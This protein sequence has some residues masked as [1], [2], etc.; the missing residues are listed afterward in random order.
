MRLTAAVKRRPPQVVAQGVPLPPPTGGWDAISPLANMPAD[1]AIKLDNWV[2]RPGWI[3]PRNGFLPRCTGLGDSRTSVQTVMAYNSFG[4]GVKLFGVAGNTIYDCSTV[5]TAVATNINALS[6]SRMQYVQFSNPSSVQYLFACNGIDEPVLYNGSTWANAIITGSGV[7]STTFI[8]VA[9]H[10]GRLWF[11]QANSTQAVYMALGAITGTGTVFDLGQFMSKGGYLVAIGTWTVDT[12]QTVDEYIAFMTS[13]GQVIVY[14]G[15]DPSTASTWNLVGRYDVGHPIGTRCFSRIA[16]DL[17]VITIDG[18]VGMSEMLST[19][20][21]AAN[22]VSLTSKIMN[23]MAIAAQQWGNNFGWQIMEYPKG[24]LSILN[25]PVQENTMQQQ[26][27]M[28]TITGAWCRFT[29]INAN[30]WEVDASDNIFFGGND[31]TVYQW[32]VGSSDNGT[33][34]TCTVETAYNAFG[35]AAQ[36]KRYTMLQ[37]L[38]TTTGTPIPAVG[39]NVDFVDNPTLSVQQPVP[40]NFAL[41]DHVIWDRFS[42]PNTTQITNNW[43]SVFGTGHYVSVVT[44]VATSQNVSNHSAMVDF[45]LNGWNIT[46]ES[47]A[48]V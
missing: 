28:N 11:V 25:V 20:R 45:Q 9:V 4:G 6:N 17:L 46:A 33:D 14:Q 48:F 2:P 37:P 32:N 27:V 18:V 30:T 24:T 19:D 16:G 5:G 35:N 26:Y 47:G 21:A 41:W 34:I 44:V 10:K 13:R 3:E 36:R 38:I 1:R 39:I 43:I 40:P 31:G 7:D 12:R 15:T 8:Q 23:Q 22:R 29:G 42:W